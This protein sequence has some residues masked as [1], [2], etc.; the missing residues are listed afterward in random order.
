MTLDLVL[1]DHQP[2]KTE[3][4][5]SAN[6]SGIESNSW[7]N[8]ITLWATTPRRILLEKKSQY[9]F[10]FYSPARNNFCQRA[11]F[12][13]R[14]NLL[15]KLYFEEQFTLDSLVC[16]YLSQN[17]FCFRRCTKFWWKNCEMFEVFSNDKS[18][19][20]VNWLSSLTSQRKYLFCNN[21]YFTWARIQT[22]DLCSYDKYICSALTTSAMGTT[23]KRY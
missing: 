18:S 22:H 9:L 3:V 13:N 10:T 23:I 19:F 7:R 16:K 15:I 6:F 14:M 20:L 5:F 8:F 21:K 2:V 17:R 1:N 11:K 12:Q 4:K